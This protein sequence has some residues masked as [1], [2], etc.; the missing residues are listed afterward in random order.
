MRQTGFTRHVAVA[1]ALGVLGTIALSSEAG[2]IQRITSTSMTC[3]AV[4]K[5][6][7]SSGAVL[8]QWISK[9]TGNRRYDRFVRN[10]SYCSLNEVT[11]TAYVPTSD[12]KSCR[13]YKCV[14]R[15]FKY[16]DDDFLLL[17]RR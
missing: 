7:K 8:V 6:V 15:S 4:Q 17:R 11:D 12:R 9:K 2:A 5:A 3:S 1:V 14:P 16:D 13:L 10:K